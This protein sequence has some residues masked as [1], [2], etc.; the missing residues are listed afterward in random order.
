M[1][2]AKRTCNQCGREMEYSTEIECKLVCVCHY[3]DCP[4]YALLQISMENMSKGINEE[5]SDG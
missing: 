2:E 4:N 1:D 3:P 5:V